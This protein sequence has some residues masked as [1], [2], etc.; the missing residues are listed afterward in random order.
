MALPI[1]IEELIT[2]QKIEWER[3]E[4][5]E[6][7]NPQDILHTICAFA[8]DIN[9]WGGGYIIIGIKEQNGKPV[10]PPKGID[11]NEV[12]SIQ[13]KLLELCNRITPHYFPLAV[14]V[15]YKQKTILVIWVPG[16]DMRPYKA[17]VSLAKKSQNAYYIRRFSSTVK[18]GHQE[19]LQ[20]M[21][22]T[23]KIPFDDR[24]N[25]QCQIDDMNL[26]FI[27]AFLKEI[28]SELYQSAATMPFEELCRQMQIARGPKEYLK[29]VNCGILF[30][31][32]QPET[33]FKGAK[34]EIVSY[35]DE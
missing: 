2:G 31:H 18:A 17:P 20:L 25:H 22:L 7:W 23:A 9:N 33:I 10:L 35:H 32:P 34:I 4:F 28:G 3:L 6:G 27:K 12:D 1:N 24:I 30:F 5:K 14:P 15:L 26:T 16:G 29:P 8:N 11:P 21:Q 13:K 19:E